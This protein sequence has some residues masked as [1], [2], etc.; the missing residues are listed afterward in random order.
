M[1]GNTQQ[2]KRFRLRRLLYFSSV[3]VEN[4]WP[5]AQGEAL[6]GKV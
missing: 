5:Q 6:L 3:S 2:M 1:L 4:F